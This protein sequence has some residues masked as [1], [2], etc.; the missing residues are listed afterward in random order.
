MRITLFWKIAKMVVVFAVPAD[1][2][3]PGRANKRLENGL[4]LEYQLSQATAILSEFSNCVSLLFAEFAVSCLFTR[5]VSLA[6]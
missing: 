3:L 5:R 2:S 4:N 1:A 6:D